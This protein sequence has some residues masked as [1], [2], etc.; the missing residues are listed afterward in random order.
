MIMRGMGQH[1]TLVARGLSF[2]QLLANRVGLTWGE[3]RTGTL[4]HEA[5]ISELD[6]C[7]SPVAL[8]HAEEPTVWIRDPVVIWSR[9]S[10]RSHDA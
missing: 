6:H 10:L 2:L 8:E 3:N 5:I 9:V 1:Q 4:E 7:A